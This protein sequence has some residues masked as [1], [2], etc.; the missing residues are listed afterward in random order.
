[1]KEMLFSIAF[2]SGL[3]LIVG[4]L[5]WIITT[6]CDTIWDIGHKYNQKKHPEYY[7]KFEEAEI[8][9]ER[10]SELFHQIY[11]MKKKI[12]NVRAELIYIPKE[13]KALHEEY[14]DQMCIELANLSAIQATV[15]KEKKEISKWLEDYKATHKMRFV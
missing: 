10:N 6:T 7:K 4:I 13:Q 2:V 9:Y 11:L 1:M 3:V 5:G 14:I 8:I 15:D 12:D